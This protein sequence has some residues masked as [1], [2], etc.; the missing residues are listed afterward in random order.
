MYFPLRYFVRY[1]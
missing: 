1:R